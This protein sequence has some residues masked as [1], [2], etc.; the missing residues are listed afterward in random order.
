M[1]GQGSKSIDCLEYGKQCHIASLDKPEIAWLALNMAKHAM[2]WH[3]KPHMAL[4][5]NPQISI[6]TLKM[7]KHVMPWHAKPH[8]TSL[9]YS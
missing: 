3:T 2:Q 5:D 4:L 6:L 1:A 8:S 9:K 7:E